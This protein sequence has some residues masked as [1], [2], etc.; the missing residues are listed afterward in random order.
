M[1]R[2]KIRVGVR[3]RVRVKV[4]IRARDIGFRVWGLEVQCVV[5]RERVRVRV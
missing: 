2:F 1:L 5:V 4:R 3:V